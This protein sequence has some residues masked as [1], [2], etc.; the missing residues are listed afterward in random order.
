VDNNV[1][2][3]IPP[4]LVP[5][6]RNSVFYINSVGTY[7]ANAQPDIYPIKLKSY[8]NSPSIPASNAYEI[9]TL[10]TALVDSTGTF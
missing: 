4:N 9:R 6:G 3:E 2:C 1:T 5:S 7:T 8:D 10:D